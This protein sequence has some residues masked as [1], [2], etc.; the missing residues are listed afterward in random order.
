MDWFHPFS[1]FLVHDMGS[2]GDG[3]PA[4]SADGRAMRT[5][6]LWGLRT[7]PSFLHDGRAKTVED[8]ILMHEGQGRPA[9]LRYRRLNPN[10]RED[11]LKF[12]G[13]L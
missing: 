10:Q 9:Q 1:D 2:L 12:L 6:P 13:T 7:Q 4:G 5:A 11:L 8:A 3:I